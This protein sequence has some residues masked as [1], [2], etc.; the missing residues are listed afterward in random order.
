MIPVYLVISLVNPWYQKV[1]RLQVDSASEGLKRSHKTS[2][3]SEAAR[4]W[5]EWNI[6]HEY[7]W[8]DIPGWLS[9]KL[10][11]WLI[12]GYTSLAILSQ[13]ILS[14]LFLGYPNLRN[15]YRDIAGYPDLPRVSLFQMLLAAG[16]PHLCTVASSLSLGGCHLPVTYYS[17]TTYPKSKW[18]IQMFMIVDDDTQHDAKKFIP[19]SS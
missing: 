14:Q 9:L 8:R 19:I 7:L 2:C 5:G 11:S 10:F 18:E 1:S 16:S 15:L 17:I 3:S 6:W 13:L 4:C 12:P